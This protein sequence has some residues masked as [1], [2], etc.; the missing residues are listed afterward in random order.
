MSFGFNRIG[1]GRNVSQLPNWDQNAESNIRKEY[2]RYNCSSLEAFELRLSTGGLPMRQWVRCFRVSWFLTNG[3]YTPAMRNRIREL[4]K[5]PP[6]SKYT[7]EDW[8]SWTQADAELNKIL[9]GY[10]TDTKAKL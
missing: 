9:L 2:D 10:C 5:W 6:P 1:I 7:K 8:L 3:W 4:D